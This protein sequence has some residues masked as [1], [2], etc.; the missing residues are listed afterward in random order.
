MPRLYGLRPSD[1]SYLVRHADD[2]AVTV[3][4]GDGVQGARLPTGVE[5]VTAA[6]R[7]GIGAAGMVPAGALTLLMTQPLGVRSVTNPLPAS[8]AADPEQRDDARRNAPLTVLAMERVVSLQ[9]AEDF[10]RAFAGVGK[11]SATAVW[12]RGRQWI[13][14]TVAAAA[15]KPEPGGLATGM[16]DHRIDATA[17]LWT[18]L[19]DALR[20]A[21]EPSLSLRLDT[22]QPVFFNLTAKV[23]IDPRLSLGGC[24]SRGALGVAHGV[25]I[26]APVVRA[27]GRSERRHHD[28]PARS[29]CGVR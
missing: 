26:R 5:N 12:R 7:S 27:A 8:G 18:N 13:H 11:C 6:Y 1:E 17:P 16:A 29:R 20:A 10:T 14:L 24:R 25:H 15:P 22:Y 3:V 23:L 19:E 21:S 4:F 2:G 9:D 28:D